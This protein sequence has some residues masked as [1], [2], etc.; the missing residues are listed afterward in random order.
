MAFRI[1]LV[2]PALPEALIPEQR[3]VVL[4]TTYKTGVAV[5]DQN[6]ANDGSDRAKSDVLVLPTRQEA[7]A[8]RDELRKAL[9]KIA[10]FEMRVPIFNI[11]EIT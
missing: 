1:V 3:L 2:H 4:R 6:L 10:G 5:G 7:E 9:F 8:K 11:E